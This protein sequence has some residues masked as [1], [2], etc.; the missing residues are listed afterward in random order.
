L[1]DQGYEIF[2]HE[3]SAVIKE[4][5]E[6][7]HN[8]PEYTEYEKKIFLSTL[9]TASL[10]KQYMSHISNI[11]NPFNIQETSQLCKSLRVY[12]DAIVV[13]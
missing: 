13:E 1:I 4:V 9:I 3:N 12:I 2:N 8:S 10:H 5:N 6:F 11:W 7:L